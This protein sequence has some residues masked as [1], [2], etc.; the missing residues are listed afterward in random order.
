MILRFGLVRCLL[1]LRMFSW[2]LKTHDEKQE[3]YQ[4]WRIVA[5]AELT[6]ALKRKRILEAEG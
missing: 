1:V 6:L 3:I 2:V 5:I 4:V